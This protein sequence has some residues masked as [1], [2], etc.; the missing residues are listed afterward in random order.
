MKGVMSSQ[1]AGWLGALVIGYC[2]L[3]PMDGKKFCLEEIER[4]VVEGGMSG[5][6]LWCAVIMSNPKV[7][8]IAERSAELRIPIL[9]HTWYKTV[10][11]GRW[12][13]CPADVAECAKAAGLDDLLAFIRSHEPPAAICRHGGRDLSHTR[14]S[15]VLL[16]RERRMLA[17][18]RGYACEAQMHSFS[19]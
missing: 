14:E 2:I 16:C 1:L 15:Y 13:S 4:C 11:K 10:E 3:N 17:G 18:T 8:C 12:E 6:K 19:L 9:Q 5:I 7:D